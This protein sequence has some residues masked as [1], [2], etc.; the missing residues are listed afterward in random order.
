MLSQKFVFRKSKNFTSDNGIQT[1][2]TIPINHYSGPTE[3]V[4]P[5]PLKTN[6]TGP[7]SPIPSFHARLFKHKIACFEHSNLLKVKGTRVL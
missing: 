7:Q 2:L 1:A 4:L 3:R 6:E 5:P